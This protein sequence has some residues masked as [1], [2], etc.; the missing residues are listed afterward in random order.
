ME[1]FARQLFQSL[2]E[3]RSEPD[4]LQIWPG[5]GAGSACGKSLGAMPQSTL[6]YEKLFNW[7]FADLSEGEFVTKVLKDQPV[8]PQY[9]AVMKRINRGA[10]IPWP[11]AASCWRRGAGAG[12]SEG[13]SGDH[14]PSEI[15]CRPY[16][17]H[18]QH[19]AE[20]IISTGWV[21]E[22]RT[23]TYPLT[24][25]DSEDAVKLILSE[26]FKIG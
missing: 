24:E 22:R 17:G 5:H 13:N 2:Q 7:A 25:A 8:P 15:C 18:A 14:D 4:H 12:V 6:G 9:F 3:F 11:A 1:L 21:L 23:A 26:L 16:S 20:Q 19:P 10:T